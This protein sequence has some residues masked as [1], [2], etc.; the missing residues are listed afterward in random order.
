VRAWIKLACVVLA[1]TILPAG[2]ASAGQGR[3]EHLAQ[4]S[5]RTTNISLTSAHSAARPASAALT[6]ITA[7]PA[8]RTA[9]AST[10]APATTTPAVTAP[11]RTYAVQRGDTL[12]AIAARFGV[13]GGWP[14]LYAANRPAIG[15]DP[16]ALNVGLVLHLPG[17]VTPVRYTV[18]AGDTLSAIAARFGV[19]GGWPALYA[20]NRP[21]IGADPDAVHAGIRLT[22]PSPATAPGRGSVPGNPGPNGT[23]PNGTAPSGTAPNGTAPSGPAPSQPRPS[24]QPTNPAAASPP[25]S[26]PVAH[27]GQPQ[28]QSH[29]SSGMPSWLKSVLLAVG[30]LAVIVFA[31]EPLLLARRR[32][33][34][35][36]VSP[37]P[38][39]HQASQALE[40]PHPAGPAPHQA[41]PVP[42]Q[43]S[44]AAQTTPLESSVS[45]I[46]VMPVP[47]HEGRIEPARIVM[48]DHDR[49]VVTRNKEDDTICVLRPPGGDPADILRVARLVLPEGH[50]SRL[51]EQLG[52]PA[53][54][55]MNQ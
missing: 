25:A 7:A 9:P 43:A 54:W 50:Y 32:R 39:P 23:A 51:A 45:E 35:R 46:P 14:A 41:S 2:V 27:P 3:P 8:A 55:P 16:D 29:A 21:A 37:A 17:P 47:A 53:N 10:T 34:R 38:P 19:R 20:A 44:P 52:L 13:R 48:A 40:P 15:P 30:L 42:H 6:S 1:W 33:R 24:T 28:P 36:G 4:V 26:P 11:A 18:T 12:S 31:A 22:I 49:L 5:L